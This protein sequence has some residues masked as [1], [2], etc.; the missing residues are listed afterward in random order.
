MPIAFIYNVSAFV[1]AMNPIIRKLFYVRLLLESIIFPYTTC[2]F[3][4]SEL[5]DGGLAKL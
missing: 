5:F 3:V 2:R 4:S 1:F